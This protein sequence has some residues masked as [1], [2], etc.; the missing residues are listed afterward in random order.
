MANFHDLDGFAFQPDHSGLSEVLPWDAGWAGLAD[1]V[2]TLPDAAGLPPAPGP[3]EG[4][5]PTSGLADFTAMASR[6]ATGPEPLMLLASNGN[7]TIIG[8]GVAN[9]LHGWG[10]D[11][12]LVGNGGNDQLYGGTGSDVAIGGTGN[13]T[14]MGQA[15]NDRLL[16]G[17][18]QDV[19]AGGRGHDE[20]LGG[21]GADVFEFNLADGHDRIL[22]YHDGT[23]RFRIF[24]DN[25]M[26]QIQVHGSGGD[27]TVSFGNT[28][29]VLVNVDYHLIQLSDFDLVLV[30]PI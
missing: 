29:F 27:T 25:L 16:G 19:L 21:L 2:E 4:S 23:D 13:D 12:R 18:G 17:A 3:T 1:P 11:D 14:L 24:T 28:S 30:Q 7:D 8:N 22:D 15:G 5:L 10:G 26:T 6:A 20:L 9:I